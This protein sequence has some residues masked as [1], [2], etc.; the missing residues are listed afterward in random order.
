MV[1]YDSFELDGGFL[2]RF[3]IDFISLLYNTRP[4][5]MTMAA[6]KLT[7]ASSC[8]PSCGTSAMDEALDSIIRSQRQSACSL[9]NH[10]RIG[11][12]Y[13]YA[14]MPMLTPSPAPTIV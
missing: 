6:R 9:C 3:S 4:P 12:S 10:C 1:Y 13:T 2:L 8:C 7:V 11:V 5:K 14:K